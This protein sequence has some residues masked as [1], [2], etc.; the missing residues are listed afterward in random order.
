MEQDQL[1]SPMAPPWPAPRAQ[2]FEGDLRLT[3][4]VEDL[5][6]ELKMG[7]GKNNSAVQLDKRI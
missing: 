3:E 5:E 4:E 7:S 2:L 6:A 1:E